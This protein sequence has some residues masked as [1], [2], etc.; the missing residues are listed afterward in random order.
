[1]LHCCM[2]VWLSSYIQHKYS[3]SDWDA[4]WESWDRYWI[5]ACW[6]QAKPC[7]CVAMI[8]CN[9][10]C[11]PLWNHLVYSSYYTWNPKIRIISSYLQDLSPCAAQWTAECAPILP[12]SRG[13]PKV[14]YFLLLS[15]DPSKSAQKLIFR[16]Q[17]TQRADLQI[18]SIPS[19]LRPILISKC[20]QFLWCFSC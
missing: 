15:S 4:F 18:Y 14:C 20:L 8:I 3:I 1:M 7:N 5:V 17:M 13:L 2:M 11:R 16:I 10:S 19:F 12:G 9:P 6:I